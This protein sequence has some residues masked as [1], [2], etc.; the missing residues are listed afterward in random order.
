MDGVRRVI[1]GKPAEKSGVSIIKENNVNE[2][3]KPTEL[4]EAP[5]PAERFDCSNG[6]FYSPLVEGGQECAYYPSV[7]TITQALPKGVGW[8]KWLG[9]AGSYE[10]AMRYADKTAQTGECVHALANWLIQGLTIKTGED[11]YDS[12][13]EEFIKLT[14]A[15]LLRVQGFMEWWEEYKP[16]PIASEILLCGDSD[17]PWA[18]TADLV[19]MINDKRW[20]ID[21]KTGKEWKHDHEMQL[22]GYEMLWNKHFP[23]EPIDR[24]SPLYLGE[25]GGVTSYKTKY[26]FLPD[27]WLVLYDQWLYMRDGKAEP[28]LPE[29]FP[30]TLNLYEEEKDESS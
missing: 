15:I 11:W 22:A 30:A 5:V 21:Y 7:T 9:N 6:R 4:L 1:L 16:I 10:E 17:M 28:R 3:K 20:L 14:P 24:R 29:E 27:Q 19:C 12:R 23:D 8:N 26:K 2:P 18:G 13:R 25:R